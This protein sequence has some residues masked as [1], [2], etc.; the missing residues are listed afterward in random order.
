LIA[1]MK[2][3]RSRMR[4]VDRRGRWCSILLFRL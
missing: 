3:L 2:M 4:T 1:R